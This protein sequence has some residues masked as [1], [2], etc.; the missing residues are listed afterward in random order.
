MDYIF[1]DDRDNN[2]MYA[3]GDWIAG[4]KQGISEYKRTVH[5]TNHSGSRLAYAFRGT[6]ISA[7]GTLGN[8]SNSSV[9]PSGNFIIDNSPA[10]SFQTHPVDTTLYRQ[11]F[12]QS[13]DLSDG[14]HTLLMTVSSDQVTFWLDYLMV[15]PSVGIRQDP[16]LVKVEDDDPKVQYTGNWTT[17]GTLFDSNRTI[18]STSSIGSEVTFSFFGSSITVFGRLP[19]TTVSAGYPAAVFIIDDENPATLIAIPPVQE[20]TVYQV[21]IFQS[22][23]LPP[24]Q[25]TLKIQSQENVTD[26]SL[27]FFLYTQPSNVTATSSTG[28]SVATGSGSSSPTSITGQVSAGAIAG[29]AIG[30]GLGLLILVSLAFLFWY[31]WSRSRTSDT[32]KL[33]S[34]TANL[35][36]GVTPFTSELGGQ[37]SVPAGAVPTAAVVTR[38]FPASPQYVGGSNANDAVVPPPEK[39]RPGLQVPGSQS[40]DR[41]E[42]QRRGPPSYRTT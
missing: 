36:E 38:Y 16:T 21:P 18:H 7:F 39:Q 5:S 17:G 8:L 29:G 32:S 14:L 26:L 28:G 34:Y 33:D 20:K 23:T 12:F 31:K 35:P 41:L 9:P 19:N 13:P 40:V 15:T 37:H 22:P 6:S 1:I 25:H 2:I 42:A 24:G 3:G 4:F 10:V 30:G 11:M 27:D